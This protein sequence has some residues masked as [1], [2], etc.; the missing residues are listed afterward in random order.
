MVQN[1]SNKG[2]Y[3]V[4]FLLA[5]AGAFLGTSLRFFWL[6]GKSSFEYLNEKNPSFENAVGKA[7][8]ASAQEEITQTRRNAIVQSAE[9]VGPAVVSISVIQI[10]TIRESSFFS[11]F[12]DD[13]F[14]DFWGR[15]FQPREYKQKVYSLGSGVII[16]EDGYIL[17]NEHVVSDADDIKITLTDGREFKGKLVGQD[18][19]SDIAVIKIEDDN[20]PFAQLG[21]SDNLI[22]GEWAIALGN[23]FGYLLDDTQPTVTVGVI[24]ALKR[25]IKRGNENERVYRKMIQTDAAINQGNSGGPLVNADGEV[26]G[27]NTF[28][29]TTSRGSEGVGFAIPINRVKNIIYDLI[30]KGKVEKGWIGLRVQDLTSLL[31]QSLNIKEEQGAIVIEVEKGSP[32]EKARI[33]RGDLI[34]EVNG[35]KI[36]N[37]DD[38]KDN[39][40]FLKP[41]ERLK[42]SLVRDKQIIHAEFSAQ[43][44]PE[45]KTKGEREDLL[46]I[47]VSEITSSLADRLNLSGREGV[48]ILSVEANGKGAGLG[49]QEGDV[50]R[51]MNNAEIKNMIDYKN[52]I[53]RVKS[54]RML[55]MVIERKGGLYMVSTNL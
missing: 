25:D 31:A 24:S 26:I 3:L 13:A 44:E 2:I 8:Y 49:L 47:T 32:A 12:R 16:S 5:L 55:V 40:S 42:L 53:S 33:K 54:K 30:N 4:V 10:R 37:I 6:K 35:E 34:T 41:G 20:F 51:E 52:A 18:F 15:F 9:K 21:D 29:F 43:K 39:I 50:I 46:G 45:V 23:P 7:I 11:P 22:I 36:R 17:T 28:I 14:D 19:S 38:Y 48:V 1:K 27:I